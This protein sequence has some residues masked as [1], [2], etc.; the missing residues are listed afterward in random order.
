MTSSPTTPASVPVTVAAPRERGWARIIFALLL[1]LAVPLVAIL[2]LLVPI[3]QTMVLIAPAMAVCALLG[4]MSGGRLWLAVIW[5]GLAFWILSTSM[6]GAGPFDA[7]ARGWGTVLAASFGVVSAVAPRR[8]FLTRAL[9]ATAMAFAVALAVI[10]AMRVPPATVSRHVTDELARRFA[11]AESEWTAR[12]ASPEWKEMVQKYPTAAT[13]VEQGEAQ[14]RSV[15]PFTTRLFAALLA[16]ES[17][18]MLALAWS[19]YHRASRTRIG[20]PLKVLS[21]FRFNDQLVWGV[22]AGVTLLVV[23]TLQ[24]ARGLGL[25]LAGFFGVLYALRGLGVLDWF[26]APRGVVRLLFYIAIF[27]AW[28]VVSV[29]SLGLGLGDTWIDWRGRARPAA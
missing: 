21:E 15:P 25:N 10:V 5:L 14:L 16:M 11:A 24:E 13:M 12:T 23:P 26:L 7:L 18:A 1:A 19:L 2:R 22:R 3:E 20:S 29:F 8:P 9:S 17:V 28:P 6:P 27:L 4:W